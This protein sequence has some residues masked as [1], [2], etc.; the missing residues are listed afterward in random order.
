[1]S[2][3]DGTNIRR[4]PIFGPDSVICSKSDNCVKLYLKTS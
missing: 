4:L 3:N 1:M 2:A